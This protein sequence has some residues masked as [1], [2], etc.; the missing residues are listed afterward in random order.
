MG[1]SHR[2]EEG[3]RVIR[4][5]QLVRPHQGDEVLSVAEVDD[6]VRPARDH[7][8][9]LDLLS[10]N[11]KADLFVRVDIALLDPRAAADDDE[12]LP[13]TV[14]PVLTLGDPGLRDIHA[15]LTVIGGLQ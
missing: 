12:E 6:V 4:V 14:M 9:G 7:M 15:E 10:R 3:V 13:L 11:L 1:S 2:L 5:E 8:H